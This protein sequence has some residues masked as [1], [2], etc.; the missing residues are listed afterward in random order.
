MSAHPCL[1]EQV[2]LKYLLELVVPLKQVIHEFCAALY[3]E[4]QR[5]QTLAGESLVFKVAARRL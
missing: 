3:E 4:P 1:V 5:E 2:E